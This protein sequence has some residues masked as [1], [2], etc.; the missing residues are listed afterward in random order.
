MKKTDWT[1][2]QINYLKKHYGKK[3]ITKIAKQVRKTR[4]QVEYMARKLG[5]KKRGLMR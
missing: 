5:L 3:S 2:W 1:E 4:G